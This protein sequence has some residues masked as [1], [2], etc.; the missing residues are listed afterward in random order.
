MQEL[1]L[2]IDH[3]LRHLD[4]RIELN[5]NSLTRLPLVQ[6]LA[7]ARYQCCVHPCAVAL[8]EIIRRTVDETL[9]DLQDEMGLQ[10]VRQ[11]LQLYASGSSVKAAS[12]HLGLSREH[13]SRVLKK[14]AVRIVAEKFAQLVRRKHSAFA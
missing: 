9:T 4:D 3:A 6:D 10:K 1:A 8:R 13:C 5:R 7:Q 12:S 11:F 2:R 14:Q